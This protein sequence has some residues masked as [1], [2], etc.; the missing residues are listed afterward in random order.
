L[1]RSSD[2]A[3]EKETE[4]Y[5]LMNA[6]DSNSLRFQFDVNYNY[7]DALVFYIGVDSLRNVSGAQTGALDPLNGMFWT[8]NTGYIMAKM[9]GSSPASTEPNNEVLFHIGGYSGINNS[10]RKVVLHFPGGAI[11]T[12]KGGFCEIK[13][14]ADINKWFSGVHAMRIADGAF[15]MSVSDRSRKF[16]DNYATMFTVKSVTNK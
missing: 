12:K 11:N 3:Q 14:D 15:A 1:L 7:Y 4:S 10:I 8:W 13:L 6:G 5:H 16:A 9:E 2:N